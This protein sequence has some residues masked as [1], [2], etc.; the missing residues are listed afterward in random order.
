MRTSI[1]HAQARAV[2]AVGDVIERHAA[3]CR[4]GKAGVH[5]ERVAITAAAF[6]HGDARPAEHSDGRT[7]ADP[8]LHTHLVVMNLGKKSASHD[9]IGALDGRPLFAWKKAIGATYHL[10]LSHE[11]GKIGLHFVR[12]LDCPSSFGLFAIFCILPLLVSG[13]YFF[14]LLFAPIALHASKQRICGMCTGAER[15]TTLLHFVY[16]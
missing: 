16:L 2:A 1:E 13:L 10:A 8:N 3:F 12:P 5:R 14:L 4:S 6:Q 11:L 9:K 15:V 7:F